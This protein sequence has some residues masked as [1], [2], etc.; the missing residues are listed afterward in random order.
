[1]YIP[2]ANT[3][4]AGGGADRAFKLGP[5]LDRHLAELYLGGVPAPDLQAVF[6]LTA[7]KSVPAGS[8]W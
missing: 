3:L 7:H 6:G 5:V 1:M 2:L 4:I 8:D